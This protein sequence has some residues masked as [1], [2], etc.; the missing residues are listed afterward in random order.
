MYDVRRYRGHVV[1]CN[2]HT[3]AI[4][5]QQIITFAIIRITFVSKLPIQAESKQP[6]SQVTFSTTHTSHTLKETSTN[7]L[8]ATCTCTC[9]RP[10]YNCI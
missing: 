8:V 5:C 3:H 2:L 1:P 4:I 7:P 10:L 6:D 9:T